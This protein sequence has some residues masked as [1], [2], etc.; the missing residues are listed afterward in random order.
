MNYQGKTILYFDRHPN[1]TFEEFNRETGGN[2]Q[3]W[4]DARHKYKKNISNKPFRKT[5]RD[6]TKFI[7][8]NPNA[9]YEEFYSATG[10]DRHLYI[11]ARSRAIKFFKIRNMPDVIKT[12]RSNGKGPKPEV[13]PE[14]EPVKKESP[15]ISKEEHIS[16]GITPDFVWYESTRIRSDLNNAISMNMHRFERLVK[17]ME[18]RNADN[19]KMI[20]DL[21]RNVRQLKEQNKILENKLAEK[22][23]TAI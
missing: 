18:E 5:V 16:L 11:Q 10:G 1:C 6:D 22:N 8:A 7:I 23:G 2:R 21:L 19:Q 17:V 4:Y 3:S 15:F 13:K 12:F 14:P 9:T 20:D